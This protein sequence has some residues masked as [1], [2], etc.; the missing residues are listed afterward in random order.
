[1]RLLKILN[2]IIKHPLNKNHKVKALWVFFKWQIGVKFLPYPVLY[3]FIDNIRFLAWKG[4]TS[5]TGNIY[6]GLYEYNDM[7]FLLHFLK[8]GDLFFDIGANIGT[9]SLLASGV[10]K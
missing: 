4:L 9:Y 5:A 2:V 8:E 3:P 10:S 6:C 7:L 1:M